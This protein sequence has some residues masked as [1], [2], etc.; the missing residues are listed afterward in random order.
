MGIAL[1]ESLAQQGAEVRLVLGP[2]HLSVVH[3]RIRT[4]KVES[5]EEM[6]SASIEAWPQSDIA[7][8]AAA[9]ADY[10]PAEISEQKIKKSED[11]FTLSLTKTVD[12]LATL[13]KNKREDQTLVGFALE[14]ENGLI[15]A[16]EKRVRKGADLMVLNSLTDMGAGFGHDTNKVTLISH[17]GAVQSLPLQSKAAVADAIVQKI[18]ALHSH[19]AQTA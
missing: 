12:I 6:H 4:V 17:D 13:G 3:D 10:R 14:T 5:A 2:T 1:A 16:H 19:A 9:V 15:H 18:I 8:L 11:A 7:V